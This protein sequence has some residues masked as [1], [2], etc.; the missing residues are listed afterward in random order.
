MTFSREKLAAGTLVDEISKTIPFLAIG[1]D[2][3]NVTYSRIGC[4][5]IVMKMMF[6]C[7]QF[8]ESELIATYLICNVQINTDIA[9][10][11]LPTTA[12]ELLL[13]IWDGIRCVAHR[14][15]FYSIIIPCAREKRPSV[16]SPKAVSPC[17]SCPIHGNLMH[18]YHIIFVYK[19]QIRCL[20][21]GIQHSLC[22][23]TFTKYPIDNVI[24]R[25]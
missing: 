15:V 13:Y 3:E 14:Q 18:I 1:Q 6:L 5:S 9:K 8:P 23:S 4:L 19:H 22:K 25:I 24:N 12:T 17:C 16:P 21:C 20:P 7:L 11:P 2:I 10:A